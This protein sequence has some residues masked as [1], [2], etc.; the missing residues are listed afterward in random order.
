M[1]ELERIVP[2]ATPTVSA[3]TVFSGSY[4][5][6]WPS[7]LGASFPSSYQLTFWPPSGP[8]DV[9]FAVTGFIGTAG[10]G[11]LGRAGNCPVHSRDSRRAML[12]AA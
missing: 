2:V 5:S 9:C 7:E 11:A 6:W 8:P 4:S 1:N 10:A 12:L 3:F